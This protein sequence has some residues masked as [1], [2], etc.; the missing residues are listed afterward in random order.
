MS[1]SVEEAQNSDALTKLPL[2]PGLPGPFRLIPLGDGDHVLLSTSHSLQLY[3]LLR[4]VTI[5]H[6]RPPASII[7]VALLEPNFFAAVHADSIVV[8]KLPNIDIKCIARL[9]KDNERYCGALNL[10]QGRLLLSTNLKYFRF[11]KWKKSR[12][13]IMSKF[14][15][16]QTV[17]LPFPCASIAD[18]PLYNVVSYERQERIRYFA[19]F[20]SYSIAER[21]EV[22]V[23]VYDGSS[24]KE[25]GTLS[26]DDESTITH[27][28]ISSQFLVT[29]SVRKTDESVQKPIL[30]FV[31]IYSLPSM[32][33]QFV[34]ETVAFTEHRF[35]QNFDENQCAAV[36]NKSS[37]IWTSILPSENG[38]LV[39]T[40]FQSFIID[41]STH[42]EIWR[43][44]NEVSIH[45]SRTL[46]DNVSISIHYSESTS[47]CQPLLQC[48]NFEQYASKQ[49][50]RSPIA[51]TLS[52]NVLFDALSTCLT[53]PGTIP[54]TPYY[55]QIRYE[56]TRTSLS[57]WMSA[58]LLLEL[59]IR[60]GQVPG[61]THFN[62][63]P[64]WW[65]DQLYLAAK[66]FEVS[67]T[68]R[69][70]VAN[71]LIVA[72]KLGVIEGVEN[73][74]GLMRVSEEIRTV[75]NELQTADMFLFHRTMTI[76]FRLDQLSSALQF[77]HNSRLSS[78]LLSIALH[79]IPIVGGVA[80]G[81]ISAGTEM[82]AGMTLK[83]IG[84]YVLGFGTTLATDSVSI[85]DRMFDIATRVLSD[86]SLHSMD[87]DQRSKLEEVAEKHGFNLLLLR[88]LFSEQ[89]NR[90]YGSAQEE[91]N[92][93]VLQLELNRGNNESSGERSSDKARSL[94]GPFSS[95]SSIFKDLQMGT[96][97]RR[98]KTTL[99]HHSWTK[100]S[101]S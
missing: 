8:Y 43:Q 1:N 59:A 12:F 76:K 27:V 90:N 55:K 28:S 73:V 13:H 72:K 50:D 84:D 68:E 99:N 45:H 18:C 19:L 101:N 85:P 75:R 44:E 51:L 42:R 41:L 71:C 96:G 5:H 97:H 34:H 91:R 35:S 92:K 60:N 74:L 66:D 70:V 54:G 62:G 10:G 83:D 33:L 87:A 11:L 37:Y 89:Q 93:Q 88:Q 24:M 4:S 22:A 6:K 65:F 86:E 52:S 47:E 17:D 67:E 58:H 26:N 36:S 95:V 14:V 31:S 38:L 69:E 21:S 3:S 32:E 48:V 46:S 23:V 30:G 53:Q 49:P 16:K 57:E 63:H 82:A 20:K 81:L 100:R 9:K 79:I 25:V 94:K 40:N 78:Q 61:T 39:G 29:S 15:G 98:L 2:L 64:A 7:D 56:Q 77:Y 80:A